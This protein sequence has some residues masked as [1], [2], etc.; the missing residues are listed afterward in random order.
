MSEKLDLD[1]KYL[2]VNDKYSDLTII[3]K[4]NRNFY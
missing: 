4:S 1:R 2:K 3:C